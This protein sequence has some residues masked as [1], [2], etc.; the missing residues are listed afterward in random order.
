MRTL[1]ELMVTEGNQEN[2]GLCQCFAG[3]SVLS[4]RAATVARLSN[5]PVALGPRAL[6]CWVTSDV[7]KGKSV[8]LRPTRYTAGHQ[9]PRLQA[10]VAPWLATP[11]LAGPLILSR[12]VHSQV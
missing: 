2:V 12:Q 8:L 3:Y 9:C 6:A 10:P 11:H 1:S 7:F 4:E 5:G